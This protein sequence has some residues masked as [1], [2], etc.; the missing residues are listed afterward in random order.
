MK[1]VFKIG[2]IGILTLALLIAIAGLWLDSMIKAGLENVGPRITRT[3]VTLDRV[4]VSLLS[5]QGR[6]NGM[7][8]GNPEGFQT[9]SALKLAD[10]RIRLNIGSIFSDR[11]VIDELEI[12]GPEVTYERGRSGSNIDQIQKNV[13][14]FGSA[15]PNQPS[16]QTAKEDERAQRKFQINRLIVKN[17]RVRLSAAFMKGKAVDVSLPDIEL[18]DIGSGSKGATLKEV[19]ARVFAAIQDDIGRA[20][21]SAGTTLKPELGTAQEKAKEIGG[22]AEKA[23]SG[24]IKSLKGLLGK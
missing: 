10:T 23:A 24:A 17:G 11:V 8:I 9:E 22:H 2:L 4:R 7:I 18:K 21:A 6:I 12:D 19:S 16:P 14:A 3:A 13:E 20:V 5:G 1:L 15:A